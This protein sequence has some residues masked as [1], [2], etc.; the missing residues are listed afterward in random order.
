L[1]AKKACLLVFIFSVLAR[2]LC[3]RFDAGLLYY[4]WFPASLCFFLAGHYSWELFKKRK[5]N[6]GFYYCLIPTFFVLTWLGV[7]KTPFD[8]LY[9][10][11]YLTC[12]FLGLPVLFEKT[13]GSGWINFLGN[14]SYPMYLSHIIVLSLLF[15]GLNPLIPKSAVCSRGWQGQAI[16]LLSTIITSI[17]LHYLI[18][19]KLL[20]LCK[21]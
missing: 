3:L 2:W 14:L 18:E 4:H 1:R 6:D 20:K 15:L 10:Y 13:K 11:G 8:N 9:F 16:F 7:P 19:K 5:L 21:A 12:I 17:L